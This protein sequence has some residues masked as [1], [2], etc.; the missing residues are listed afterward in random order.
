M[1]R[2]AERILAIYPD[3]DMEKTIIVQDDGD[4][5][6]PYVARWGDPRPQ[7]TDAELTA[8]LL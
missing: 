5:N 1:D 6:G 7:P 8:V 2:L 4:G 3:A